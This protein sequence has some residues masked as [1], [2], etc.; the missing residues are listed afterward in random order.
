VCTSESTI[1]ESTNDEL[2]QSADR[3]AARRLDTEKVE[4]RSCWVREKRSWLRREASRRKAQLR[5]IGHGDSCWKKRGCQQAFAY[6]Q[7][8]SRYEFLPRMRKTGALQQSS[9]VRAWRVAN[10]N[11]RLFETNSLKAYEGSEHDRLQTSSTKQIKRGSEPKL[12]DAWKPS[13]GSLVS[14][15]PRKR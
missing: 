8:F 3:G 7:F 14:A 2:N 1:N 6:K 12:M 10:S 13:R 4:F 9:N 5:A 11:A 15:S